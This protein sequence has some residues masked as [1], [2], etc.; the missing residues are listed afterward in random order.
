MTWSFMFL[1]NSILLGVGLAMDA[2]AVSVC[3]GLTIEKK[4]KEYFKVACYFSLFQGLMP[5]IGY[6]L[7]V[8]FESI[9]KEIDHYIAFTLLAI[10]GL[11]MI[12]E[13][14]DEL[15]VDSKVDFKTMILLSIATSIDALA[16]GVTFTF[17]SVNIFFSILI[18]STIT[19]IICFIGVLVGRNFGTKLKN[20]SQIFGGIILILIGLKILL[21]HLG[22]I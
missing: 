10:I 6:Y 2:F 1:F 14:N 20:K 13:K 3:K 22:V 19:F 17:L 18:I 9:I 5:L 16:I 4:Y 7:G 11:S 8:S 21:E 15:E 12:L